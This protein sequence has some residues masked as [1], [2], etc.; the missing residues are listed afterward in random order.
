MELTEMGCG[1]GFIWLSV[2]ISG[3]VFVNMIMI[4]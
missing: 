2:E 1:L 3:V 4:L